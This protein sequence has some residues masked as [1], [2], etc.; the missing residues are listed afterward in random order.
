M[1]DTHAELAKEYREELGTT[2]IDWDFV[3]HQ[4]KENLYQDDEGVWLARAYLG[5]ILTLAPSGKFWTFWTTNATDEDRVKDTVW[6]QMLEEE[7][8]SNHFWTESGEGDACD[9]Y[10]V[11][12]ATA[13]EVKNHAES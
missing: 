7:A 11:R 6:Y 12:Y 1:T 13:G 8:Q 3:K 9:L 4:A 2:G 10:A 5:S